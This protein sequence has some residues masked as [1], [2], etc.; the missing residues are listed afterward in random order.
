MRSK[1]T[2]ITTLLI[3]FTA[4]PLSLWASDAPYSV[5]PNCLNYALSEQ[6][7]YHPNP[8]WWNRALNRDEN[9]FTFSP[10]GAKVMRYFADFMN[11]HGKEVYIV[12]FPDTAQFMPSGDAHY[13]Q[14]LK[15]FAGL[16]QLFNSQLEDYGYIPI[17]M[18][19]LATRNRLYMDVHRSLDHHLTSKGRYLM[20]S[21]I[22]RRLEGRTTLIAVEKTAQNYDAFPTEPFQVWKPSIL[23]YAIDVCKK[24]LETLLFDEFVELPAQEQ[25]G[26]LSADSLFGE[27]KAAM[28]IALLGTSQ[29]LSAQ[30][31]LSTFLQ[32]FSQ[33]EVVNFSQAGGGASGAMQF[34]A[35]AG[36]LY[37]PAYSALI[38]EVATDFDEAR[39]SGAVL[40]GLGYAF[41]SCTAPQN[42]TPQP[43]LDIR[44]GEWTPLK[45]ANMQGGYVLSLFNETHLR[46]R[47]SLKFDFANGPPLVSEIW[48]WSQ[49]EAPETLGAWRAF[50]PDFQNMGLEMPRS[51]SLKF[52]GL[53]E[54]DPKGDLTLSTALCPANK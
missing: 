13:G 7:D 34:A 9:R 6:F 41:E 4:A 46:G 53:Y 1:L 50:I 39:L 54:Y 38:W 5:S 45:G 28:Q 15:R 47:A 35:T 20:A 25:K 27:S 21:Q 29:S 36:V 32:H 16:Y 11:T 24:Q 42:F 44:F 19:W 10:A 49:S 33:K 8:M 52:D 31:N 23:N 3:H 2:Y 18:M 14:T 40:A 30:G 26:T 43:S 22:A 51:I 37:D 12:A 48:R 17:D